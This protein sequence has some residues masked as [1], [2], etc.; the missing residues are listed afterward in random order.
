MVQ[1][2][3]QASKKHGSQ[4]RMM[5]LRQERWRADCEGSDAK[6]DDLDLVIRYLCLH[7]PWAQ[8]TQ[9]TA[10]AKPSKLTV[11]TPNGQQNCGGPWP[12]CVESLLRRVRFGV[13]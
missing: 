4:C 8:V 13:G 12:P 6:H 2:G 7:S 5:L 1:D 9:T 11:V 10:L 3:S